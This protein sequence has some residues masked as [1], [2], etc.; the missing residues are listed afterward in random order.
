MP[1]RSRNRAVVSKSIALASAVPQ[2]VAYRVARMAQAQMPLS[3]RDRREFVGMVSEKPLAF[4]Q[5]WSAVALEVMRMNQSLLMSTWLWCLNPMR[6][7]WPAWTT[8]RN[9]PAR[10]L[11]E[12]LE[13]SRRK[14]V[15]NA[16]RLS[17]RGGR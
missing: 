11:A 17:R 8:L 10:L 5:T 7:A 13:P 16:R 4:A 3:E 6:S 12:S 1:R 2:V 9:A 15:A 14:A